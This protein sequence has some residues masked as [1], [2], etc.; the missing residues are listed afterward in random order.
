MLECAHTVCIC[1][2][3]VQTRMLQGQSLINF[4]AFARSMLA[5]RSMF[6]LSKKRG[7]NRHLS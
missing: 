7:S 3:F 5:G 2:C 6:D 4:A 1:H